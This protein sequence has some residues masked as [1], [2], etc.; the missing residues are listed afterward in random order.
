MKEEAIQSRLLAFFNRLSS[1]DKDLV[2]KVSEAIHEGSKGNN[3]DCLK[4]NSCDEVVKM[5]S[6]T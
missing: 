5:R 1:K 3:E 2:L 6:D 4:S